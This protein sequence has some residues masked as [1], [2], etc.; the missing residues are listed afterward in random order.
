MGQ[1]F[2]FSFF[3]VLKIPIS[4][5]RGDQSVCVVT[6][7]SGDTP[8]YFLFVPGDHTFSLSLVLN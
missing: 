1:F 5:K 6:G 3:I 2:L 8:A 7:K 4:P